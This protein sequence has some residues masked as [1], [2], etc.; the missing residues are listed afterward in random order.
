VTPSLRK[1]FLR[2]PIIYLRLIGIRQKPFRIWF[3]YSRGLD[4]VSGLPLNKPRYN[5]AVF[6]C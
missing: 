2:N 5:L 1:L 4:I 3:G 6:R